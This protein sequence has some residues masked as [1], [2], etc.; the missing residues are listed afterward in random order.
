MELQIPI[1]SRLY[2][3]SDFF[4][5]IMFIITST[6]EVSLRCVSSY[7]SSWKRLT[8]N[9]YLIIQS[10]SN[11]SHLPDGTSS[12]QSRE[13]NKN[14]HKKEER[15]NSGLSGQPS[16]HPSRSIIFLSVNGNVKVMGVE[17]NLFIFMCIEC[18]KADTN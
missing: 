10:K 16:Y 1:F 17:I 11:P 5:S 3:G 6:R 2:L 14:K 7:R 18:P 12:Q 13:K 15:N 8:T 4:S 9:D